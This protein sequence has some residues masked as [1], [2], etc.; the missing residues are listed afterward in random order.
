MT[1]I[2]GLGAIG[3]AAIQGLVQAKASRIIAIDLNEDKYKLAKKMRPANFVFG[4][5]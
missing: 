4:W 3:L 2:F 1:A 5:G